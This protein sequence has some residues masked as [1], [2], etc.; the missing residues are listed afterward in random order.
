MLG[1]LL[2]KELTLLFRE[3][4]VRLGILLPF[5]MYMAMGYAMG[6]AIQETSKAVQL[7]GYS[8]AL[9]GK[10]PASCALAR[11]LAMSLRV[12]GA[13]ATAFC[14]NTSPLALLETYSIVFEVSRNHE[15]SMDVYVR[16]SLATLFTAV[17]APQAI[18]GRL[19]RSLG[20]SNVTVNAHVLL[21]G[22]LWSVEDLQT[23][24]GTGQM[25]S[26]ALIF[27]AFPA[28][29]MAAAVMGSEREERMLETMLS[30]PVPRRS[31]ALAKALASMAVGLAM[32]ASAAAGLYTM[33]FFVSSGA[34]GLEGMEI[35][36]KHYT[37]LDL[38]T[39]AIS[40]AGFSAM[41]VAVS[42]AL[43]GLA[44][45]QRGAQAV[46]GIVALPYF[47]AAFAPYTGALAAKWLAALPYMGPVYTAYA[48]LVGRDIAALAAAAQLA[49][50]IASIALLVR[51][52]ESE[53]ILTGPETLR[54]FLARLRRK[55]A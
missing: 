34:G 1:K 52:L 6:G 37:W 4:G 35:T 23:V 22:R 2:R 17:T 16:G 8:V 15:V 28:A 43:G 18:A 12:Q 36:L 26:F 11:L 55:P 5:I 45:S 29:G 27:V 50:A 32:A 46:A 10:D 31:I 24:F 44:S 47:A 7:Q 14:G 42:M 30:L 25:L 13:N 40:L 19:V 51:L 39:Y 54:R 49:Y 9:I 3:P 33:V 21:E 38:A 53:A 20:P 48:P 41:L